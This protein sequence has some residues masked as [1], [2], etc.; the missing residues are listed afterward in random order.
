MTGGVAKNPAAVHF[1]AEALRP[2]VNVPSH[3]QIAG[4][5]RGGSAGPR[6]LPGRPSRGR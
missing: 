4:A 5:L 2:E 3:P 6:R 1:L